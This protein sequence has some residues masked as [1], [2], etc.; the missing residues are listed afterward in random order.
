MHVEVFSILIIVFSLS[1]SVLLTHT[2]DNFYFS[3]K[4]EDRDVV[5]G[6]ELVLHC[7]VSNRNQ[8]AFSWIQNGKPIK[9]TSRKFQS[10]RNLRI[11]RV[12][13]DDD[14][15]P[16]QCIATNYTSGYS[17][18]SNEALL[19]ILCKY[20]LILYARNLWI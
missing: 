9:F 11:L 10:G 1:V 4:P 16:F 17:T 14:R 2:Q 7:D 5:E 6:T 3:S 12:T 13:R 15:G 18:Q 8:I 19:N 20:S